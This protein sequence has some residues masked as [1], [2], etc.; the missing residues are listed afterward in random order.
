MQTI[1]VPVTADPSPVAATRRA[2]DLARRMGARVVLLHVIPPD[3]EGGGW[4]DFPAEL[5][6]QF[7]G[8][9]VTPL[10]RRGPVAREILSAAREEGADLILMT[11]HRR[12]QS[13]GAKSFPRFL[14]HSVLCRILLDASC[15]VW[16]EPENGA[17]SQIR[18]ILCG[19]A[20]LVHDRDT[21]S[22]AGVLAQKLDAQLALFRSAISAAIAVPG[23]H[24]QAETW[25]RD[26]VA[27]VVTDLGKLR[28]EL[29]TSGEIRVGIGSFAP[30]LLWDA[31][32]APAELVV[33]RRTSRDWGR[34]QTINTLVRGAAMPVLIYPG[35]PPRAVVR[36]PP[37]RLSPRLARWAGSALL[38]LV[39]LSGIWLVH[40]ALAPMRPTDCKAQPQLCPVLNGFLATARQRGLDKPKAS[41]RK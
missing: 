25:Q 34:D 15:P 5:M 26:M 4:E 22:C 40:A 36:P 18:R 32:A 7:D 33:I 2:A 19:V 1:L 41:P 23:H 21:I 16:V 14:L 28:D 30:A 9:A 27:A 20:S 3:S 8:L 38:L 12:W 39:L 13:V 10:L 29:S 11:P 35:A 6:A 24:E 31:E 37:R 17:P